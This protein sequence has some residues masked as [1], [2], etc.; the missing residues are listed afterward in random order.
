M[1]EDIRIGCRLCP[2]CFGGMHPAPGELEREIERLQSRLT[3]ITDAH[4]VVMDEKCHADE[5]HCTCVPVLR[6]EVARLRRELEQAS[7]IYLH[8]VVS[9]RESDCREK[10]AEIER[11]QG[12]VPKKFRVLRPIDMPT[13]S[14]GGWCYSYRDHFEIHW[15]DGSHEMWRAELSTD[16]TR[17]DE[18]AKAAGGHGRDQRQDH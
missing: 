14:L 11:L 9:Q 16:G 3:E 18:A 12:E 13:V 5:R 17:K 6:A 8:A 10:D 2:N 1:S 4:R 15:D 7:D